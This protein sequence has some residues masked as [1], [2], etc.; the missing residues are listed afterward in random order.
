MRADG[1]ALGSLAAIAA[2]LRQLGKS[3][4]I[5]V[6]DPF[7]PRYS[8][9]AELGPWNAWET[10]RA[11]LP[12]SAQIASG[13]PYDA[14]IVVDTCALS[15]LEPALDFLARVPRTL[16]IDHHATRDAIGTG[17][18]DLRLL[19]ETA[20]AACVL[21]ADWVAAA[22]VRLDPPLATALYTGIATDT[23]WFRFSN[24]DARTLRTAATLLD[25]GVE[26]ARLYASIYQQEPAAKLRLVA[27]VLSSLEMHAGGRLAVMSLRLADFAAAGA[28]KTMTEDLVNEAGRIAGVEA[29]ILLTEDVDGVVRV[30]LR[31]RERLDVAE[32]ARRFGGGGHARAAGCRLRGGWDAAVPPFVAE[33]A[34]LLS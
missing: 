16:V 18:N 13:E 8:A 28:D 31:S 14:A 12:D 25:A 5:A 26:P 20:A 7:P 17:A 29:T 2:A 9:I 15:Q 22:G 6:F 32:L 24:A 23:G 4:T 10:L 33:V 19:D 30:N 1:D 27:R 3:P 11:A 21:V 34:G